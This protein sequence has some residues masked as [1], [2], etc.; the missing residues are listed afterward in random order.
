MLITMHADPTGQRQTLS[1]IH[2][3]VNEM[4]GWKIPGDVQ[5][6]N[7]GIWHDKLVIALA[8]SQAGWSHMV[9]RFHVFSSLQNVFLDQFVAHHR[10]IFC[11]GSSFA[12]VYSEGCLPD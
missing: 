12:G 10:T 8:L 11:Q 3:P 4:R 6:F 2:D 5:F 9:N 1:S 7:N